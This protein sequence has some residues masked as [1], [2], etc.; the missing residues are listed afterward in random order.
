MEHT[1]IRDPRLGAFSHP[2]PRIPRSNRPPPHSLSPLP[3]LGGR[4]NDYR[5]AQP[6]G[7]GMAVV[8]R[9]LG[10]G[11]DGPLVSLSSASVMEDKEKMFVHITGSINL[12]NPRR[13]PRN[14]IAYSRRF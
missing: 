14:A 10:T 4:S 8:L 7:K 11:I 2:A 5:Q 12:R 1:P 9:R 13:F 6:M 3:T